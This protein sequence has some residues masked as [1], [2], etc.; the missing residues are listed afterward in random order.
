VRDLKLGIPETHD[1]SVIAAEDTRTTIH[2][3]DNDLDANQPGFAPV[4]VT[5]A[6]PT[7]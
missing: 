6:A 5:A 2:A 4:I 3:L 7:Y 1:D